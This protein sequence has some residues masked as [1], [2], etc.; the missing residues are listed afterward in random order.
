M[1]LKEPPGLTRQHV[2]VCLVA[3]EQDVM[4]E[5]GQDD[6]AEPRLKK[7]IKNI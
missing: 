3:V 1:L 2:S 4:D 7:R 5:E 6:L